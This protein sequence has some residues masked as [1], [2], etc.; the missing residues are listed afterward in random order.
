MFQDIIQFIKNPIYKEDMNS[1]IKY[2]FNVLILVL[3]LA[4]ALSIAL[5]IVISLLQRALDLDF[6]KHAMELLF[7]QYSV[8]FIFGAAILIAP[9]LEEL[10]FRGPLVFFKNSKFFPHI[11]Y[12]T[13]LLFAFYHIL[14]FE[15]TSTIVLFSPVLVAPQLAVGL[16]LGFIR[17]R[18]G[19][20]WAILLH[21]AYN[22]ILVGPLLLLKELNFSIT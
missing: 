9:L 5:G 7:D 22:F 11:F 8:S 17:V 1:D 4:I 19:L 6:G 16:L 18:L 20:S 15:I 10:I 2:K 13:T 12:G 21:A 3:T 14:N